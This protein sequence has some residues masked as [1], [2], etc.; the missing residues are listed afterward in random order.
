MYEIH[1]Q[2][3]KRIYGRVSASILFRKFLFVYIVTLPCLLAVLVYQMLMPDRSGGWESYL[4][5]AAFLVF[6]I[7]LPVLQARFG[8]G[9][10]TYPTAAQPAIYTFSEQGVNIEGESYRTFQA[11]GNFLRVREIRSTVVL[12]FT[13]TQI[14]I[15]PNE[16]FPSEQL[17]RESIA[18]IQS[19][20]PDT[21]LREHRSSRIRRLSTIFLVWLAIIL[22]VVVLMHISNK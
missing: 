9:W 10:K 20:I 13:Q 22:L 2:L 18:F 12:F 3:T 5:P 17:R 8:F 1:V 15:L 19:H 11:W 16:S 21:R 14:F 4:F 6:F 7:A